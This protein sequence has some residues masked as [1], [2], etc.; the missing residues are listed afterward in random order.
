MMYWNL[1]LNSPVRS[2]K[3]GDP[4]MYMVSAG[5]PYVFSESL[6]RSSQ[7]RISVCSPACA[8]SAEDPAMITARKT[9]G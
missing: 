5:S 2:L 3:R 7:A 8:A 4:P 9:M 1:S 6:L